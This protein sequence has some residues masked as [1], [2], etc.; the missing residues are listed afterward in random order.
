LAEA[1]RRAGFRVHTLRGVAGAELTRVTT[2]T[3][4][5]RDGSQ[6]PQVVVDYRLGDVTISIVEL[7]DPNPAAPYEIPG[8]SPSA[9]RTIDGARYLFGTDPDGEVRYIQFKRTDGIVFSVNFYGP[10]QP[11][12]NGPGAVDPQLATNVIRHIE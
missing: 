4:T 5:F 6:E 8:G 10:T 1:E 7:K 11:G 9:I 12:S 2:A 3:V